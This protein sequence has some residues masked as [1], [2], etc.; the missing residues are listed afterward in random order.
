MRLV[1]WEM[2]S[3]ARSFELFRK[4]ERAA[5]TALVSADWDE[6]SMAMVRSML[7]DDSTLRIPLFFTFQDFAGKAFAALT[8]QLVT[9]VRR[10]RGF[11]WLGIEPDD[12]LKI[13]H[14]SDLH[15]GSGA[16]IRTLAGE[17]NSKAFVDAV[18]AVWPGGPDFSHDN[19]RYF[20]LWAS[21][22]FVR[23]DVWLRRLL[24]EF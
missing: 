5:T 7:F 15:F 24:L 2:I 23:A 12:D 11:H 10:R 1:E 17:A 20:Q 13:L 19:R 22:D 21:E 6:S 14:I 4:A 8:T 16:S 18:R 9:F 3:L